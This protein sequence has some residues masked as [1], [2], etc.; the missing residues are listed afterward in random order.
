MKK[1]AFFDVKSVKVYNID[2]YAL[3]VQFYDGTEKICYLK[4]NIQKGYF[5]AFKALID[6]ELF[7]KVGV[8]DGI[9]TWDNGAD[10]NPLSMYNGLF[11]NNI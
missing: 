1:K 3:Q 7:A 6:K 8:V 10:I 11:D 5:P 2:E 9:V 4:N